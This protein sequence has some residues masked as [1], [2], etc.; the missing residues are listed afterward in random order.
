MHTHRFDGF[1]EK[2][3]GRLCISPCGQAEV[4]HLAVGINYT[5]Q[6]SQCPANATAGFVHVAI[7]TRPPQ[8]LFHTLGQPGTEL[9][10][11][12]IDC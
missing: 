7:Y 2:G 1:V 11:P 5:P 9:L 12:A 4:D 8:M 3:F 10:D 6:I